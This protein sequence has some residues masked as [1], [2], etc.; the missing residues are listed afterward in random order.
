VGTDDE[1]HGVKSE[2]GVGS[3]SGATAEIPDQRVAAQTVRAVQKYLSTFDPPLGK[4]PDSRKPVV[5]FL[6]GWWVFLVEQAMVVVREAEKGRFTTTAPL[7]RSVGEHADL[8]LWLADA[9]SDGITALEA[10]TQEDQQ[11][12]WDSYEG[13]EGHPPDGVERQLDPH[14]MKTT[15]EEHALS[16]LTSAEQRMRSVEGGVPYYI[17]RLLSG[18]THAGLNTSRVFAPI[19]QEFGPRWL[20]TPDKALREAISYAPVLDVAFRCVTACL[21][22]QREIDDPGLETK[23]T[24]WCNDMRMTSELPTL[25]SPKDSQTTAQEV[26]KS[27]RRV[28]DMGLEPVSRVLEILAADGLPAD[29]DAAIALKSLRRLEGSARRLTALCPTDEDG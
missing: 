19:D 25:A 3:A 13:S 4:I 2:S 28:R 26:A 10:D 1:N 29:V 8:M 23:V 16:G 5:H 24:R 9:G 7:V 20:N 14:P 15:G 21:I 27:A 6:W 11:K 17:Y 22:F 18:L 12:L